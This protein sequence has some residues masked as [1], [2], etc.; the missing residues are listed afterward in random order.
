MNFLHVG[1]SVTVNVTLALFK[2]RKFIFLCLQY[3]RSFIFSTPIVTITV[4]IAMAS[5]TLFSLYQYNKSSPPQKSME[6]PK[7]PE[8]PEFRRLLHEL[9]ISA[10]AANN[11]NKKF[12]WNVTSEQKDHAQELIYDSLANVFRYTAK[13]MRGK[14][15]EEVFQSIHECSELIIHK[16]GNTLLDPEKIQKLLER[17]RNSGQE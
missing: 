5:I 8:D 7:D 2:I 9:E 14:S 3:L 11:L 4:F 15:T 10:L 1:H 12:W 17:L 13:L 16:L 6:A